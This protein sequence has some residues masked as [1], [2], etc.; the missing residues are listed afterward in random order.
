MLDDAILDHS[1]LESIVDDVRWWNDYLVGRSRPD[2]V[3]SM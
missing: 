3:D 2:A 1:T